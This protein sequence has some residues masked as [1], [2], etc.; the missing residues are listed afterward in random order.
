[1]LSNIA[2]KA[3]EYFVFACGG[4]AIGFAGRAVIDF[5]RIVG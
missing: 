3:L 5:I 4:A 2:T 1:M